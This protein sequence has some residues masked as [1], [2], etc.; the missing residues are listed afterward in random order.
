MIDIDWNTVDG[1]GGSS[2]DG[3]IFLSG[4]IGQPDA[5]RMTGLPFLSLSGGYWG[6]ASAAPTCPADFND[7]GLVDDADF[8]FFAGSYDILECSDSMM[9][10]GCPADLNMDSLV[11][12]TDFVIFADAYNEL[13]CP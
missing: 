2:T 5:G 1:G 9:P 4:T 11:D 6:A 7:D 13:L 10:P 8:V 12:D 3:T